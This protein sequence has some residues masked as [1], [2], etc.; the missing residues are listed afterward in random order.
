MKKKFSVLGFILLPTLIFAQYEQKL[1][2]NLSVG[3]FK[4][5]GNKFTEY[6]G[7]LQMPNYKLGFSVNGE[8]QLRIGE[9][10]SLAT[11][12]GIMTTNRWNYR[13]PDKDNWL[14]WTIEDTTTWQVLEEGEDYLDLHNYSIFVKPKYY[15]LPGKKWNPYFF[16][17]VNIDWTRAWFENNL[18]AAQ[19]KWGLLPPDVTTPWNDNLE[20]SFGIGFNPGFGVEYSSGDKLH[21]Y[22]E[23]GYYF[24]A[25][26]KNNFKDISRVENFNA[27]IFQ[28]GCRLNFIKSKEL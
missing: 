7:P 28:I 2:V 10:F 18:W 9:H 3:G 14:Y 19:Y 12:F 13:T 27:V 6:A 4:T 21:F 8:F 5:F 25:L 26:D 20:E 16:A 23:T 11:G 17:G 22:I 24:I 15:L 1:S